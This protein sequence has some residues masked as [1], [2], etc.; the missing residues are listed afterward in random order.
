[1]YIYE[2]FHFFKL[3]LFFYWLKMLT[4]FIT[5]SMSSIRFFVLLFRKFTIGSTC[6]VQGEIDEES[7]HYKISVGLYVQVFVAFCHSAKNSSS[8]A[9]I[10]INNNNKTTKAIRT[11]WWSTQSLFLM[12][13][14]MKLVPWVL[15]V[16]TCTL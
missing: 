9:N 6:T 11:K 10:T 12:V 5:R 1:M 8:Q 16:F 7:F 13:R 3:L 14:N 4:K 15:G 2:N